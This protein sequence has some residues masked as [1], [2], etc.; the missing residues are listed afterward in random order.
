MTSPKNIP[1]TAMR[2]LSQIA[3][4]RTPHPP[5]AA[6]RGQ[7]CGMSEEPSV[8]ISMHETVSSSVAR[9]PHH[10]SLTAPVTTE[11]AW[12]DAHTRRPDSSIDQQTIY[13]SLEL[14]LHQPSPWTLAV[15]TSVER[16]CL[17]IRSVPF[18]GAPKRVQCIRN[19]FCRVSNRSRTEKSL[20][21]LWNRRKLLWS[22]RGT[23]LCRALAAC[24]FLHTCTCLQCK[25][26]RQFHCRTN[27]HRNRGRVFSRSARV[28]EICEI[29][30]S[31][32]FNSVVQSNKLYQAL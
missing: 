14:R 4:T 30:V 6:T 28:S 24:S 9:A 16:T 22:S 23:R 27:F 32:S 31:I 10:M 18:G 2:L 15:S 29:A 17:P 19:I 7:A 12:A 5:E 25:S 20:L 1:I 21:L 8:K 26:L 3:E 13:R 11:I